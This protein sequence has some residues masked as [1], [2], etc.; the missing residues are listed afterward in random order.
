MFGDQE[1]TSFFRERT[2]YWANK[3]S[4]NLRVSFVLEDIIGLEEKNE[5]KAYDGEVTGT[6]VFMADGRE[7]FINTDFMTMFGLWTEK[8]TDG[9]SDDG[10]KE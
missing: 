5:V 6:V 2:M 1:Y 3:M 4:D 10:W 7:I 9:F 8:K